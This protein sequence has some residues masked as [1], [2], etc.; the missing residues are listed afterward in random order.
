MGPV[1]KLAAPPSPPPIKKTP[2]SF[3]SPPANVEKISSPTPTPSPPSPPSVQNPLTP[4]DQKK[5]N[6]PQNTAFS[7]PPSLYLKPLTN[8]TPPL[9]PLL[10]T[11]PPSPP[12]YIPRILT[13]P[14][15][16]P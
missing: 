7:Y 4:P 1:R 6:S 14:S 9:P 2:T 3:F 5:H 15:P 16:P 12:P 10:S 11:P 8:Q 13:R